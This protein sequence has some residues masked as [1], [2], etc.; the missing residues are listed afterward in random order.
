MPL[1]TAAV[2]AGLQTWL[3]RRHRLL[4]RRAHWAQNAEPMQRAQLRRIL[5]RAETT[6]FG[7]THRFAR[8]AALPDDQFLRAFRESLPLATYDD[9][10][11]YITRMRD[12][13][14][15]DVLWPGLVRDWAQ[16]SGTTS[17]DKYIPVS[18]EMLRSNV[19]AALD[20]YAHAMNFG[21]SIP[22]IFAGRVLVLGGSTDL[23]EDASGVRTGDLS[24]VCTR[25]VRWPLSSIALPDRETALL[26]DWPVKID[27]MARACLRSD[28]RW[29]N[30]M[31]SWFLVLVER[32]FAIAE[33]QGR[34]TRRLRD[35]LPNLRVF[36]HGGVKYTPFERR[37]REV[38]SGD[39]EGEDIPI[40]FEVY[41][42]SEGFIAMQDTP[43][44]PGLRLNMDHGIYYEF[45]PI[46]QADDPAAP[47][48]AAHE[49]DRG[50]RYVV[51][52]STCAGLWRYVIGD[53]VEFDTIPP[54]G[55]PRL[56]IVGRHRHFINAFGENIIV[57]HVENAVARAAQ[58]AGAEVGEFTAAPVYPSG[59]RRAGLELA[60][61][62]TSGDRDAFAAA[63]DRALKEQNVDYTTK[64][65]EDLGMAP[66]TITTLT[67]GAFHA[68]LDRKGKLGGQHKCPRCA[69]HREI[70]EDV[71]AA[72]G[73]ARSES[74][75]PAPTA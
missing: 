68:W 10:R 30:G 53:V 49:V 44:D 55:P 20:I 63:F 43:R 39:P 52:M 57:E 64:R 56:R 54:D 71:M 32:M 36:V 38:W 18:R 37:I 27:R 72:V 48:F 4:S 45:V 59:D 65:G 31:P 17:G 23:N 19:K 22:N 66:P 67:P 69:N 15:P 34:P 62:W 74:R 47:A 9:M 41:P 26:D 5:T 70:I 42:A 46:E 50:Q 29:V 1:W 60:I 35:L 13:A 75:E 11:P 7:R 14:E 21:V 51:V 24:G 61:E 16:T 58:V 12:G 28:V 73:S 2:G 6:E 8:L 3:R 25:L 40:R 33:E